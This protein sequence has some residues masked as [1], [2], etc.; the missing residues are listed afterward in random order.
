MSKRSD[1]FL[2]ARPGWPKSFG[3]D[4]IQVYNI[5]GNASNI[6]DAQEVE[7]TNCGRRRR[8]LPA[9]TETATAGTISIAKTVAADDGSNGG[10]ENA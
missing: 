2:G 9:T 1:P 3:S 4:P 10:C 5:T 6:G 8:V 7:D